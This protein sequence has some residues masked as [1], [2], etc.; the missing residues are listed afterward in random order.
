MLDPNGGQVQVVLEL[1]ARRVTVG[2][3]RVTV[4]AICDNALSH[5]AEFDLEIVP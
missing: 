4:N 3:Y 1:I 5:M 2:H